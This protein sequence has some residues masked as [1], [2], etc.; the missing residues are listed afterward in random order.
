MSISFKVVII[1][2]EATGKTSLLKRIRRENVI[3]GEESTVA[4][5]SKDVRISI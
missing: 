5:K 4:V 2:G 3:P 1:G